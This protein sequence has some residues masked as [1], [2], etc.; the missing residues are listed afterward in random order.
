MTD[1]QY[2]ELYERLVVILNASG[3]LDADIF[4]SIFDGKIRPIV[5]KSFSGLERYFASFDIEDVTND[6]F[7][8]LWSGCVA[9]YFSN[10]KY[11]HSPTW[12][13]GWCKVVIKNHIT[14]FLRKRSLRPEETLDDPEH[15]LN[16]SDGS[17]PSKEI[18]IRETVSTVYRAVLALPGKPEMKLVWYGVYDLVFGREAYDKIGANRLFLK[19]YSERPVSYLYSSVAD[20]ILSSEWLGINADDLSPLGSELDAGGE[21]ALSGRYVASLLGD[22][23][24]A[25]ISDWIYKINKKLSESSP[26]EVMQWNT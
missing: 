8:K 23:P 16:V 3:E 18:V 11:E 17:D 22:E 4:Y 25:K 12:F 26:A 15:P 10:E 14:S 2:T 7:V 13:L 24:L 19:K 9:A 20:F 5:M 21:D 6:I 1:L